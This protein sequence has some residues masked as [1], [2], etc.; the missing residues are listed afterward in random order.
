MERVTR[1]RP[2]G[3]TVAKDNRPPTLRDWLGFT[4]PLDFTKARAVGGVLGFTLTLVAL[5]FA[6]LFFLSLAAAGSLVFNVLTSEPGT[7]SLGLGALLVAVL[8]APFL[9]WR[10]VV[11]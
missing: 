9:I 11:A 8:G 10:T 3:A 6:A 5:A 1:D 7:A 2:R 4:A